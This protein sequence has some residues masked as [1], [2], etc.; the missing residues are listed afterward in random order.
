ML[1]VL[2]SILDAPRHGDVVVLRQGGVHPHPRFYDPPQNAIYLGHRRPFLAAFLNG[3]RSGVTAPGEYEL[4]P[5]GR[6]NAHGRT[7]GYFLYVAGMNARE[8]HVVGYATSRGRLELLSFEPQAIDGGGR[9]VGA[10]SVPSDPLFSDP[11][12]P[13]LLP[14]GVLWSKG[15]EVPLGLAE[16]VWFGRDGS[17]RGYWAVDPSGRPLSESCA[18]VSAMDE[19]PRYRAFSWVGG[20]RREDARVLAAPP[21]VP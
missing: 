3:K 19:E 21:K 7:F 1:T 2:V 18:R 20:R 5:S 4:V 8:A 10:R 17:V 14:R 11:Y 16:R 9:V 6:W 15:R 13:R 12:A